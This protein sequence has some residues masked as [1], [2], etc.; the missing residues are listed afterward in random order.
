MLTSSDEFIKNYFWK[1][2]DININIEE[3]NYLK[4][5]IYQKS[6]WIDFF[7]KY[8]KFFQS[9]NEIVNFSIIISQLD[10]ND[11]KRFIIF[12]LRNCKR[13]LNSEDENIENIQ[14]VNDLQSFIADD[15]RKFKLFIVCLYYYF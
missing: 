6:D 8:Q 2:V 9:S 10:K 7:N 3:A 1:Y 11:Y 14:N 5:I 13:I 12:Y 15:E 4:S